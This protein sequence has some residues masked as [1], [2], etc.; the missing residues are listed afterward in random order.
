MARPKQ[1]DRADRILHEQ[2][3]VAGVKIPRVHDVLTPA[4]EEKRQ[5]NGKS[6]PVLPEPGQAFPSVSRAGKQAIGLI[7]RE[8]GPN[9]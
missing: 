9:K 3:A 7:R 5:E 1:I 8:W 2:Q 6:F 4:S